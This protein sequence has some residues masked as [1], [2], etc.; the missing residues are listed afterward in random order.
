[1]T[2]IKP[3]KTP[4]TYVD[5]FDSSVVYTGGTGTSGAVTPTTMS[6][7]EYLNSQ[8]QTAINNAATARDRQINAAQVGYNQARS[9]Y[10]SQAAALSGMGLQG[11]GYSQYLDSQAYAQKNA[12]IANAY[13]T[14]A[15]AV[16]AAES[17]YNNA[18]QGY[19][20]QQEQNRATAFA[21]M[22][23]NIDGYS[24]GDITYLGGAHKL[25]N[26]QIKYLVQNALD[27]DQYTATDL[28]DVRGII[29][30]DTYKAYYDKL[31]NMDINTGDDAFYEFDEDG[32]PK[33]V[34]ADRAKNYIDY[35][36]QRGVKP[37]TVSALRAKYDDTYKIKTLDGAT[38]DN[39][40]SRG[41][42]D[43]DNFHIEDSD[44]YWHKVQ[45][46]GEVTD[47][48]ILELAKDL[49]SGTVFSYQGEIYVKS[50]GKV[51]KVKARVGG[52]PF[53][54]LEAKFK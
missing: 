53:A 11:S 46:G 28:E 26:D 50:N 2:S 31:V 36:E 30:E 13:K 24:L 8:K 25:G 20:Q 12:A 14:E 37:E 32:N 10:G 39:M 21:D 27:R 52:T 33:L 16:N 7:E 29:G 43:G 51:Y 23:K 19:L 54:N 42:V 34:S 49:G 9:V 3:K 22:V 6:Y 35:L 40:G 17:A 15:N 18:Y 48:G 41:W 44:G 45:S 38:V 4:T 5:L 47:S 1:M